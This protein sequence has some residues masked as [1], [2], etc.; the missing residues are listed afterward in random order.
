MMSVA[1]SLPWLF[2]KKVH[3]LEKSEYI[4]SCCTEEEKKDKNL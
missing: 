1:I 3:I 4:Y 2:I